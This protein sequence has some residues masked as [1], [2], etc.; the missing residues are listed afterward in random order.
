LIT[1]DIKPE[2]E[3]SQSFFKDSDLAQLYSTPNPRKIG[4]KKPISSVKKSASMGT[5]DHTILRQRQV[6]LGSLNKTLP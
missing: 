4:A 2:R 3:K 1:E 5:S 6:Q